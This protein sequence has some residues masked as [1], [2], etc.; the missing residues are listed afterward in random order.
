M[1]LIWLTGVPG[2]GK[3]TV[4]RELVRR[5]EIAHDADEDGSRVWLDR[6]TGLAVD[7]PGRGRRPPIWNERHWY[8]IARDRVE[9][10][11][12]SG[13]HDV[14]FLAGS[15]P[16]ELDVWDLFDLVLCLIVDDET[17]RHRLA[18][19]TD[20]DFGKDPAVRDAVLSWNAT[21]AQNYT[22]FGAT[23]IDATRPLEDVVDDVVA[24]SRRSL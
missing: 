5:G 2:A 4:R 17:L 10:L 24:A 22:R 21:A 8:P 7:D 15:V 14:V 11:R 13:N 6:A 9:S 12:R 3:S 23:L 16:N 19:R 1:P 20:N 18:S